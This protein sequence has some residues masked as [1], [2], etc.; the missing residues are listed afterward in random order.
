MALV[1][2]PCVCA[3]QAQYFRVLWFVIPEFSVERLFVVV[4]V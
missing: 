3:S 4:A 2:P 1:P